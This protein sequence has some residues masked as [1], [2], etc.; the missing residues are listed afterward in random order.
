MLSHLPRRLATHLLAPACPAR[1]INSAS[2]LLLGWLCCSQSDAA[3]A[4]T[5][6]PSGHLWLSMRACCSHSMFLDTTP[7]HLRYEKCCMMKGLSDARARHTTLTYDTTIDMTRRTSDRDAECVAPRL[8]RTH[9]C[10]S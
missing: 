6:A 8:A 1:A 9:V 7:L 4:H 3:M 2:R 5:P 10:V